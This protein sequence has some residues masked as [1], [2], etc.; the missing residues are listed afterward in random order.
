MFLRSTSFGTGRDKLY[1]LYT[2]VSD[3]RVLKN[4]FIEWDGFTI[5]YV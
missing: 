3:S 4:N 2:V 1:K 5:P